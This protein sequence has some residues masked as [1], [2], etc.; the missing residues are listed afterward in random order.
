[1]ITYLVRSLTITYMYVSLQTVRTICGTHQQYSWPS[2]VNYPVKNAETVQNRNSQTKPINHT[3]VLNPKSGRLWWLN[4]SRILPHST[5]NKSLFHQ[6]I[7]SNYHKLLPQRSSGTIKHRKVQGITYKI[8]L[9]MSSNTT[10]NYL[11]THVLTLNIMF[12]S[13]SAVMGCC[14]VWQSTF[15]T[16]ELVRFL[17]S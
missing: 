11:S 16:T 13:H 15:W 4:T 1:M 9:T 7:L 3:Q 8:T 5:F 12:I 10:T 6:C 17:S 14:S 2:N